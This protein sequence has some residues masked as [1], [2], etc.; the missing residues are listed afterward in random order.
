M[1]QLNWIFFIKF[2]KKYFCSASDF[3]YIFDLKLI[4]YS[5]AFDIEHSIGDFYSSSIN[6]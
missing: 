6:I 5:I 2:I 1:E 3:R 4:I